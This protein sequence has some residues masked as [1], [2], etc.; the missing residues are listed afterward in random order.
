MQ[1]VECNSYNEDSTWHPKQ[2][3]CPKPLSRRY[4]TVS[5]QLMDLD[6]MPFY[7]AGIELSSQCAE[8]IKPSISLDRQQV[9]LLLS[10][11]PFGYLPEATPAHQ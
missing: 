11:M 7:M 10:L 5:V 6:T 9:T 3:A 1:G 8:A 2:V 4:G